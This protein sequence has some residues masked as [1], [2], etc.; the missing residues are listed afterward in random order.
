MVSDLR[1]L[2]ICRQR[3]NKFRQEH[4]NEQFDD[5]CLKVFSPD[6]CVCTVCDWGPLDVS[7]SLD[8]QEKSKLCSVLT[9]SGDTRSLQE[10][11]SGKLHGFSVMFWHFSSMKMWMS[12]CLNPTVWC[13]FIKHCCGLRLYEPRFPPSSQ[14]FRWAPPPDRAGAVRFDPGLRAEADSQIACAC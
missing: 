8:M 3:K 14:G 6:S 2:L 7:H 11:F 1:R 12:V 5:F 13:T 10:G 4:F 9:S